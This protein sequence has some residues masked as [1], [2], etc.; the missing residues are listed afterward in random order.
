MSSVKF[1]IKYEDIERI[2]KAVQECE[3]NVED[4]INEYLKNKAK[5]KFIDSITNL[6]PVSKG[7]Y[8]SQIGKIHAKNSKPLTGKLIGNLTLKISTKTEFNYLYFPQMA[9]GTSEGKQPNDFMEKGIDEVYDN[10]V[11]EMLNKIKM[12]VL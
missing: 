7:K 4:V 3:G 9:E 1:S 6:I 2:N 5:K 8:P 10:V 12:E 11:N